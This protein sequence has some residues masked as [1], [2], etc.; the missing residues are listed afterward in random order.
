VAPEEKLNDRRGEWLKK[1]VDDPP[2][3]PAEKK[4]N[5]ISN[6]SISTPPP[7]YETANSAFIILLK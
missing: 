5:I 6:F 2:G 4:F 7:A 1:K 3:V